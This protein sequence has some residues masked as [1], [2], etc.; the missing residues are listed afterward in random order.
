MRECVVYILRLLYLI[1]SS[2]LS[3][4]GWC[5]CVYVMPVLPGNFVISF[6]GP[7]F[8]SSMMC[9]NLRELTNTYN[10]PSSSLRSIHFNSS[11]LQFFSSFP[12]FTFTW[13][14]SAFDA[15]FTELDD[16]QT[17]LSHVRIHKPLV[18]YANAKRARASEKRNKPNNNNNNSHAAYYFFLESRI[19][20]IS[21]FC[22]L[23]FFFFSFL[24]YSALAHI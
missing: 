22:F 7:T 23:F 8:L 9:R 20:N 12:F 13:A 11:I 3:K 15:E 14:R 1:V 24:I 10:N 17:T 19:L 2:F 21:H 6:L 18:V 5:V 4:L 16:E